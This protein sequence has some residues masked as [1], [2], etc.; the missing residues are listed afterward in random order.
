MNVFLHAI[1]VHAHCF[2]SGSRQPPIILYFT[3]HC[4]WY[5]SCINQSWE[6][7]SH[8]IT[9]SLCSST[10]HEW[11]AAIVSS[12]QWLIQVIVCVLS[13]VLSQP[14]VKQWLIGWLP[15]H[16]GD[17]VGCWSSYICYINTRVAMQ[18]S[19]AVVNQTL[20]SNQLAQIHIFP[21]YLCQLFWI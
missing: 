21:L 10:S 1:Q 17:P 12:V 4:L 3:V 20:N 14:W 15:H 9:V 13:C 11:V 8:S 16:F 6:F 18:R 19:F 5:L 2:E 7:S